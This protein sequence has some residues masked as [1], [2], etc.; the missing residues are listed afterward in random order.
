[1]A[2]R[3]KLITEA[4]FKRLNT[5]RSLDLNTAESVLEKKN[6]QANSLLEAQHI[7]DDIKLS[8]YSNLM[9]SISQQV[10]KVLETPILVKNVGSSRDS[11][12][13]DQTTGSSEDFSTTTSESRTSEGSEESTQS[14]PIELS[15]SDRLLLAKLPAKCRK[16]AGDVMLSFKEH[17]DLVKWDRNG[18]VAFFNS[19]FESGCSIVD[20]ISYLVHDLKWTVAPKGTNRFLLCVKRLNIPLSLMRN[21]IRKVP[22]KDFEH[23]TD[24]ASAGESPNNFM[25]LKNRL[26]NWLP[27]K[28]DTTYSMGPLWTSTPKK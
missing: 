7:P 10:R 19:N 5:S 4:D 25:Q 14:N 12:I 28:E 6:T 9:N 22:S 18:D 1:M 20:L 17:P 3:M 15:T 26:K 21:D 2:K 23:L 27:I 11:N 16:K 8:M 24:I 13:G